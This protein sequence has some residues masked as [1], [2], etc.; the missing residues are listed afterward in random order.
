[1]ES[2]CPVDGAAVRQLQPDAVWSSRLHSA[3]LSSR[4]VQLASLEPGAFRL[5]GADVMDPVALKLCG[6]VASTQQS[7][8]RERFS[9]SVWNKV[10]S[11]RWLRV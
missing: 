7:R 10:H 6:Q 8:P 4:E 2:A 9:S 3:E 1:M 11:G 5:M